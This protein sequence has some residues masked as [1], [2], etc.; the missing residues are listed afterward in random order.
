MTVI[1]IKTEHVSEMFSS[2]LIDGEIHKII[3]VQ[4][5]GKSEERHISNQEC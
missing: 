1:H 2:L 3:S 4:F 5:N